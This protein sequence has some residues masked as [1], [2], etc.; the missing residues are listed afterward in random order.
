MCSQRKQQPWVRSFSKVIRAN[1]AEC[2]DNS[3]RVASA[4]ALVLSNWNER[5]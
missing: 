4:M 1:C 5:T 3:R 2:T